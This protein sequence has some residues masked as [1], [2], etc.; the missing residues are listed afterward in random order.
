MKTQD[1]IEQ[2]KKSQLIAQCPKCDETFDFSDAILFD[3][4]KKF[5]E[6]ALK[7]Q[8]QLDENYENSVLELKKKIERATKKA[9]VTTEA[10]NI[11]KSLEK[12]VPTMKEF[13]WALPDSRFLFDPIDLVIF[14]GLSNRKVDSISFI[15]IKTGK[16]YLNPHQKMVKRA[17][18]ENK[19][20]YC[21][22][23]D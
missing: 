6:E 16:S 19:I 18:M 5:P 17:I 15:E 20:R 23:Y 22:M 3:G 21:E 9:E 4:T 10:V 8:E 7:I 12:I 13:K 2:L 11:G 14:N 1:I